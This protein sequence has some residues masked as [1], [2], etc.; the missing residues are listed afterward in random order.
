MSAIRRGCVR[1]HSTEEANGCDH[2][3]RTAI[4]APFGSIGWSQDDGQA[5]AHVL[6]HTARGSRSRATR[7]GEVVAAGFEDGLVMLARIEDGREILERKTGSAS[8]SALAWNADGRSLRFGKETAEAGGIVD[9]AEA[10]NRSRL[11]GAI[12]EPVLGKLRHMPVLEYATSRL[13][14]K[15]I[16]CAPCRSGF[17]ALVVTTCAGRCFR[18]GLMRQ[19]RI[20]A[21]KSLQGALFSARHR[22]ETRFRLSIRAISAHGRT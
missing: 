16:R 15:R 12:V 3:V 4:Y 21:G 17:R 7:P 2:P 1:W 5:A 22:G 20:S 6:P 10:V 9:L 11:H 18:S 14:G 13:S 19:S 8:V